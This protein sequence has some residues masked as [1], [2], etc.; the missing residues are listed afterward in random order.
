MGFGLRGGGLLGHRLAPRRRRLAREGERAGVLGPAELGLVGA[1]LADRR[2]V[3]LADESLVDPGLGRAEPGDAA[4]AVGG[5][6]S[7]AAAL[8]R[9]VVLGA[10]V[11]ARAG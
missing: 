1:V 9:D 5:A 3:A 8:G 4:M 7:L 6:G 2:V 11:A 10:V